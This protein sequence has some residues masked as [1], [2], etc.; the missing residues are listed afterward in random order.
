MAT[1]M[2]RERIEALDPALAATLAP[3]PASPFPMPP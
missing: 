3:P 2:I 1:P